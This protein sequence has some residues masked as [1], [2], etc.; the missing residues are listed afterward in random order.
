MQGMQTLPGGIPFLVGYPLIPWVGV[1]AVG[2]ALG[3]I[4]VA[5]AGVECRF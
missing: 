5:P 1:M 4:F 3:P 2:Y